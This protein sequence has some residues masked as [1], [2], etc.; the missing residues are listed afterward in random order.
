MPYNALR[1]SCL[2]LSLLLAAGCGTL[3]ERNEI[4]T[5]TAKGTDNVRSRL[6]QLH[7]EDQQRGAV[8]REINGVWL[9]GKTVK[10]ARDAELPAVFGQPI[11][12]A[13]PDRP[14]LTVIAD[15]ISKIVNLQIRVTPDALMP[16]EAFS[17]RGT[18]GAGTTQTAT[19]GLPGSVPMPTQSGPIGQFAPSMQTATVPSVA[20]ARAF[21]LDQAS[22]FG[23]TLT[24][25]LDQV[26]AKYGVGW[27]YKD[28]TI[29]ISRLVTRTYQIAS[30]L[31]TN[32]V[33]ATIAKTA[34]SGDNTGG[35]T[36]GGVGQAGNASSKTDVSAKM[37][38]KVDVAT[39][40]EKAI[41]GAMTPGIGKYAISP[42]GIVTVTDTREVQEQ[43]RELIGAENRAIGRQVSMR[44]QI[45]D[46]TA[47]TNNDTGFDWSWVINQA[48]SKWNVNFFSPAG[49]PG[50][51]TGFGQLGVI[52][53]GGN[54]TTQTFLRALATVG[55]V[56]IR[57]DE[58]YRMLNNRPVSI[59][60]TDTFI[61][62]AR[63]TPATAVAG[64]TSATPGI[65]PGQLTTG[66]F[67][68]MRSAV[69][70][71]GSVVVQFSLDSSKRGDT[72]QLDS[73]G[74]KLQYPQS[75]AD[76]YQIY[77]SIVNGETAVMAG[78]DDTQQQSTD[79]SFD[80]TLS[81]LL[82]GGIATSTTRRAVLVL[83]TPQII[84]GVN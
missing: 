54:S 38:A 12:F 30:I 47:T 57:K 75:S 65:D 79:K 2:L 32:D 36:S 27:D 29:V 78:T 25:L 18:G 69:Q 62:P 3:A 5:E 13:F 28:G 74:V 35:S 8:V 67:L 21:I 84:E 39:G 73:N 42:S 51:S 33:T 59:A 22:P 82:G 16:I 56:N 9:G 37:T 53:N 77:A 55:K 52:R 11:R 81:A 68:N 71:N 31:D 26:S 63:S 24:D 6:E 14:T 80:S 44:V 15:R 34:S 50:G 45:V 19:A 46:F 83:L 66:T 60:K 10:V 58:T 4:R 43:V 40:L 76:Q 64:T 1:R 17:A 61:Y 7:L 20:P 41:S 23:G 70:P 48:T 49:L 72:V